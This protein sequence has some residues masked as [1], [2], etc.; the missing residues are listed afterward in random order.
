MRRRGV[1]ALVPIALAMVVGACG[2][3]PGQ[4]KPSESSG[5]TPASQVKTSGFKSLGPVT[6]RVISG[7]GSGGPRDAL[8]KLTADFKAKYP[9]VTVKLSFR[10]TASW[11]KQAKLV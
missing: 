10:D 1:C 7:E 11:F 4:D 9:N 5:G 2:G 8:R 3:T 6:L